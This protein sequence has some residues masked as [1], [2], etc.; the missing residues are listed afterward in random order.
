[1]LCLLAGVSYIIPEFSQLDNSPKV[2]HSRGMAIDYTTPK[3]YPN[4]G[5]ATSISN[6]DIELA[7]EECLLNGLCDISIF[8]KSSAHAEQIR[9][10]LN[11]MA[12]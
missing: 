6:E 5:D 3:W 10:Q 4:A 1:M 11:T 2:W 12:K 7:V 9:N 8:L